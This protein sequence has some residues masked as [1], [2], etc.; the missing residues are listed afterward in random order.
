MTIQLLL[1]EKYKAEFLNAMVTLRAKGILSDGIS[2][3]VRTVKALVEAGLHQAT[4][5][6]GLSVC[7]GDML[8]G[9]LCA[10][11]GVT[12]MMVAAAIGTNV[13]SGKVFAEGEPR[14]PWNLSSIK[15]N[16]SEFSVDTPSF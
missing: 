9:A 11:A 1:K 6:E 7:S 3:R 15:G 14:I 10:C 2:R 16:S 12:I 8:L 13:R 4:G 5:G